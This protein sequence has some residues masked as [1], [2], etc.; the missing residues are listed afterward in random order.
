MKIA[1]LQRVTLIDFPDRIAA[2]VF[3]AGCNL[4]CG[5]CHNRGMINAG[6]VTEVM[7]PA[8]L[9]SW[10]GTRVG[11]LDGICFTGG[12]PL[13]VT[14]LPPL[15]ADIRNLGF[16]IKLD[17]NGC[18][19]D[20]LANLLQQGQLDYVAMD[21]KAPLDGRYEAATGRRVDLD[22]IRR[23]MALLRAA[24]VPWE[25]RTTVHPQLGRADLLDLAQ[26]LEPTDTWILQP[27]VAA[28]T[29]LQSV[30]TRP[31]LGPQQLEELLPSLR[32][33][34]PRVSLR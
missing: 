23:S 27:F 18:F 2:T 25:F 31:C 7:S 13:M 30:R 3:I 19:P 1:G 14:D 22:N 11:K 33:R 16:A 28:E 10:L 29:V 6:D 21:I 9:L 12:E 32:Q 20:R 17:T 4:D 26:D 5:F 8:D 15:I 24:S 34:V